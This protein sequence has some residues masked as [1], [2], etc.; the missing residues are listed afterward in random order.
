MLRSDRRLF[1]FSWHFGL[2]RREEMLAISFLYPSR[3]ASRAII[4]AGEPEQLGAA[5]VTVALL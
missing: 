3:S 2:H 1:Y 4:V 5:V